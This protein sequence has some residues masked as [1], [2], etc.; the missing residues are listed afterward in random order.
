MPESTATEAGPRLPSPSP[1]TS[2]TSPT[3]RCDVAVVGGG[4]TGCATAYHLARAGASVVL[5][6]RSE[7]GT[8]ASGRNA[9]SLHGQIQS[10]SYSQRG[11]KWAR[12]FLPAL[13]FLMRSLDIW[14]G[15]SEELGVDLE[16]KTNGGLLLVDDPAQMRWVEEKVAIEREGGLGSRILVPPGIARN[17]AIRGRRHDRRRVQPGGGK[18]QPH[19][20]RT[21][22]CPPG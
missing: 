7:V 16:V 13:A 18:S 3:S 6:E 2:P 4:I 21:R 15:L 14:R 9:G 10:L 17:G 19:G 8:E 12:E 1:P 20:G 5:L 22:F 11:P